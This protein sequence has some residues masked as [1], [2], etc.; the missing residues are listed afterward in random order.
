MLTRRLFGGLLWATTLFAQRAL[1]RLRGTLKKSARLAAPGGREIIL[2]GDTE[3]SAVLRD[4][5]LLGLELEA[6]GEW[7]DAGRFR[8][9][10]VHERGLF[11]VR[12]GK[13]LVIT[14]WC[15]VCSIRT[16]SPGKCMCCQE[17]TQL[18]LRDPAARDTDPAPPNAT[19]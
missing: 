12:N 10:P 11:V 17:E 5:R 19:K 18:D 7:A 14:Y 8:V 2:E 4:S 3:T 9:E 13:P 6:V 16:Y 15:E 1:E